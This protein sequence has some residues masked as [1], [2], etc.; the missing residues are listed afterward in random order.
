MQEN[1]RTF[2]KKLT[3]KYK[4]VAMKESSF[5]ELWH[6]RVSNAN[7][8]SM[9]FAGAIVVFT[10]SFLLF[11]YSSMQ[12]LL[13]SYGKDIYGERY[14]SALEKTDSLS[15]K[16]EAQ[17]N[18]IYNIMLLLKNDTNAFKSTTQYNEKQDTLVTNKQTYTKTAKDSIL[19][20]LIEND[21]L[22]S[23]LIF[24]GAEAFIHQSKALIIPPVNGVLVDSFDLQKQHYGIDVVTNK[25]ENIKVVLAGTV[26]FSN[27]D[28][29]T[30]FTILVQH[31]N[32]LLS[33]YKHCETILK[34][35]G[36]KVTTGEVIGMVGNSGK[37]SSGPHLHF[38]LWENGKAVDP[39][40]YIIFNENSF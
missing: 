11:S 26:I 10:I 31:S 18:Y 17:E 7:L 38:E 36:D 22:Q 37:Y 32:N 13:P 29:N 15:T 21:R 27:W 5:E 14:F 1:N 2:Y 24:E 33:S 40:N 6:L 19:R 16:L 34:Q 3:K 4:L 30:G 12:Y 20:N 8:L 39:L 25:K 35:T 28:Y 23:K 9:F